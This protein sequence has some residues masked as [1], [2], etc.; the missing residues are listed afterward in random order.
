MNLFKILNAV[1]CLILITL[2]AT[3]D[4]SFISVSE[5]S[6]NAQ[7]TLKSQQ[8][9][10]AEPVGPHVNFVTLKSRPELGLNLHPGV[11]VINTHFTEKH[12]NE[13]NKLNETILNQSTRSP[14]KLP[15]FSCKKIC[16]PAEK[17]PPDFSGIYEEKNELKRYRLRAFRNI[18][19]TRMLQPEKLLYINNFTT[20]H[21]QG[22]IK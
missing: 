3:I 10:D 9:S 5:L 13:L 15:N 14:I 20:H 18:P 2:V 1:T 19:K 7:N 11:G 8:H 16:P 21:D 12:L 17:T 4:I 6:D 22:S